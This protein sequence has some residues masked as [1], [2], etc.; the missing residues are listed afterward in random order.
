M[1]GRASPGDAASPSRSRDKLALS[2]GEQV[3]AELGRINRQWAEVGERS[4]SLLRA[5]PRSVQQLIELQ[6]SAQRLACSSQLLSTCA[7]AASGTVK[8]LQQAGGG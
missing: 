1:E 7:E 4:S 5:A 8:R 6:L 2:F 3:A